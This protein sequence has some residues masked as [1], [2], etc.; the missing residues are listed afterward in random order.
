MSATLDYDAPLIK[1]CGCTDADNAGAIASMGVDYIGL[2]FYAP[3]PR[4]V[5][6]ARAR[7]LAFAVRS[8]NPETQ[9]VGVFVQ[10]E[11]TA[12]VEIAAALRLNVVQL[13]GGEGPEVIN[14]VRRLTGAAVWNAAHVT[15]PFVPD[16]FAARVAAADAMVFDSP[17]RGFGGSGQPFDWE[18]T[19]QL[20]Q[21][22][23]PRMVLA[24]GLRADNVQHAMA[25]LQP[26][27]VDTASG[28]EAS[29]GIKD[30]TKVSAF[31]T[32]VRTAPGYTPRP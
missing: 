15:V 8:S 30:I 11:L 1:I 16:A 6:L 10:A 32:A 9:L 17:S 31:L 29:P 24:G 28:V 19:A 20:P 22:R 21:T 4:S 27:A 23:V 18:A 3:S 14:A 7:E 13:H 12:M 26:W 25:V 2:N 5:D